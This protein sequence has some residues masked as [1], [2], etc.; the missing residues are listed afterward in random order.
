LVLKSAIEI[1]YFSFSQASVEKRQDWL[2]QR[3]R[4]GRSDRRGFESAGELVRWAVVKKL[5]DN[6]LERVWEEDEQKQAVEKGHGSEAE[7]SGL[8]CRF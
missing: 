4:A 8:L 2:P 5:E 1:E 7:G 6:I 3:N